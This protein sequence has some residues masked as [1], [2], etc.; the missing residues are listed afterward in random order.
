[1][2]LINNDSQQLSWEAVSNVSELLPAE[3]QIGEPQLLFTKVEDE[4]ITRQIE[5]T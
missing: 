2:L 1:M 3:H 5:K 4:A